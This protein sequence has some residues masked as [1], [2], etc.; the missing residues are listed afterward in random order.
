MEQPTLL[1]IP[2]LA[3]LDLPRINVVLGEPDRVDVVESGPEVIVRQYSWHDGSI[4]IVTHKEA[5]AEELMIGIRTTAEGTSSDRGLEVGAPAT[6]VDELYD[7][8]KPHGEGTVVFDYPEGTRL[9]VSIGTEGT[10]SELQRLS[11]S[12]V[13]G[14]A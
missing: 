14:A 11:E 1:G 3:Y 12:L 4:A 6:K 5:E 9:V 2:V 7:D 8:A 13:G 10:V